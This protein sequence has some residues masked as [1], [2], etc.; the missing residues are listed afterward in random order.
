GI[1]VSGSGLTAGYVALSGTGNDRCA[2]T[3]TRTKTGA[4]TDVRATPGGAGFT[5]RY[6]WGFVLRRRRR[7][8]RHTDAGPV[9]PVLGAHLVTQG[10]RTGRSATGRAEGERQTGGQN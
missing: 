4:A 9:R 5:G 2:V 10:V 8:G 1:N 6:G 3:L 7:V